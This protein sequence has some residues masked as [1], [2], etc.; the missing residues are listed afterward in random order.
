MKNRDWFFCRKQTIIS[1]VVAFIYC[2]VIVIITCCRLDKQTPLGEYFFLLSAPWVFPLLYLVER[3]IYAVVRYDNNGMIAS[4]FGKQIWLFSWSDVENIAFGIGRY[5]T[6]AF[7]ISYKRNNEVFVAQIEY[8][9]K[10][11][12]VLLRY[13]RNKTWASTIE[14]ATLFGLKKK[15]IG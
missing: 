13:C 5:R 12:T 7:L 14:S 15:P 1:C 6:N 11:K 2:Y 3:S 4:R 8:S 9:K 10:A